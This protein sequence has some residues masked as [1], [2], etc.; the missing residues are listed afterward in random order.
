MS[1]LVDMFN[2]NME[3]LREK[4]HSVFPVSEKLET[5]HAKSDEYPVFL[6]QALRIKHRPPRTVFSEAAV[7]MMVDCFSP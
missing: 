4:S 5:E 6:S 3:K 2:T 1:S 7:S